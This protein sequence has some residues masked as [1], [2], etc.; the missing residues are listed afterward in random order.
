MHSWSKFR[1]KLKKP[2]SMPS[3]P[4]APCSRR[5][6]PAAA[7][8]RWSLK[9]AWRR[10]CA[11]GASADSDQP[12]RVSRPWPVCRCTR[13]PQVLLRAATR[14]Q[15]LTD[16]SIVLFACAGCMSSTRSNS[17]KVASASADVRW[18]TPCVARATCTGTPSHVSPSPAAL[19]QACAPRARSTPLAVPS[20]SLLATCTVCPDREA[21]LGPFPSAE[22]CHSLAI[23]EAAKD[24]ANMPTSSKTRMAMMDTKPRR[25]HHIRF[26]MASWAFA[27]ASSSS[28][29]ITPDPSKSQ[30]RKNR[31]AF[32]GKYE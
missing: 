24:M 9:P 26:F 22:T 25:S 3:V 1:S 10:Y 23:S 29:S 13:D 30:R 28:M 17:W 31:C 19:E 12:S 15:E 11:R 32:S 18:S 21:I 5:P 16:S 8:A 14:F 2:R 4:S 27:A 20:K 7:P 6:K